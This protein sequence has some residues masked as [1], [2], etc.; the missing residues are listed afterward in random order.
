MSDL[1][2]S[3]LKTLSQDLNMIQTKKKELQKRFDLDDKCKIF[4]E[5]VLIRDKAKNTVIRILI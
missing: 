1:M 5:I 4:N 3:N 2:K